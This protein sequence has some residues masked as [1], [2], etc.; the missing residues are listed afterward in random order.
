[1]ENEQF[2]EELSIIKRMIDRTRRDTFQSGYLFIVLG[3]LWLMSITIFAVLEL[4]GHALLIFQLQWIFM[5]I[6]F[7][8]PIS[9]G[10]WDDKRRP[11]A[12]TYSR[13]LFTHLWIACTI[14]IMINVFIAPLMTRDA[15]VGTFLTI[16]LGFYMTGAIYKLT[17]VQVSGAVFWIGLCLLGFTEGIVRL[18]IWLSMAFF[19]FILPGIVLNRQYRREGSEHGQ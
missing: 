7:I 19:G 10:L 5:A 8:V 11:K 4:T 9:I 17:L 1:M 2:Q 6:M 15:A 13:K 18:P 14:V 16:G 3:I 12:W